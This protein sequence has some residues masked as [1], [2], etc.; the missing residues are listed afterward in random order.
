MIGNRLKQLRKEKDV[1]QQEISEQLDISRGIYGNYETGF[2]KPPIDVLEKLADYFNVSTDY[3]LGRTEIKKYED[4]Q[5]EH[6]KEYSVS[7]K[8]IEYIK[9][10]YKKIKD[11]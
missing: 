8:D 9:E 5:I 2:A 4:M 7:E 10:L 6:N 3:L 11:L 1:T